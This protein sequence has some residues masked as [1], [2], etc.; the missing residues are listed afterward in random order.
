MDDKKSAMISNS[1]LIA[2]FFIMIFLPLICFNR[3]SGRISVIENKV[4]AARPNLIQE[5][6]KV[7]PDYISEYEDYFN[8][9]IGLKEEALTANIIFKYK[10][11]GVL[12][13]P[14]WMLGKDDNLF[15]TTGGEDIRT[16]CGYNVYSES[17]M[18]KIAV[19]LYSMNCYFQQKGCYTYN[20]F[21]PNKEAVYSDLYNP[22]IYH[23][24]ESRQDIL[25]RYLMEKTDLSIINIK[26]V[27]IANKEKQL[28]YKSYDA[29]HWNMNGAYIGYLELM[30]EIEKDI[31]YIKILNEDDFDISE[32][33]YVG[34]M[35]YYTDVESINN[36]FDFEDVIYSYNLKGGFHSV[37]C[38]NDPWET[39][40][41]P[42]LNYYHFYNEETDNK[43][44]LFIVGD[45]YMY[46]FL[47]PMFA[48]SFQNVYFIRNTEAETII[49]LSSR[50][51]PDVFVFEIAERVFYEDYYT[52]YMESY[53]NYLDY[54]MNLEEYKKIE[55]E[56]DIHIDY[57]IVE[58]GTM[59]VGEEDKTEIL[60]WAFDSSNDIAPK[61][62][63]A[64]VDGK[65]KKAEF[66]YREDLDLM[67][68]KYANCGFKICIDGIEPQNINGIRLYVITENDEIY[69]PYEIF[70]N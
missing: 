17:E 25:C 4:L 46:C 18:Q 19:A 22:F 61:E 31:P 23:A 59:N 64:E 51:E 12:D 60:G 50:I 20:M 68:E 15:Y 44:S 16:Y 42:N 56:P 7:N 65:Y 21:I 34:L 36:S 48:E 6:G 13:I 39:D 41:D 62:V 57:P 55:M 26:D 37:M 58:N 63:I 52:Y 9:N 24:E 66:Y 53:R 29:S 35:Q 32:E 11:F 47:L 70:L 33:K 8:D 69:Q 40:I 28:Y 38:E 45:S 10:L 3:Q 1:I 30:K 67:G 5:N 43:K 49:D 27:L 2:V 14:N 54:D